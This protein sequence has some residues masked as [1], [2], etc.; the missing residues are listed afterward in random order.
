MVHS[1]AISEGIAMAPQRSTHRVY[2]GRLGVYA[3][4]GRY[5]R[6]IPLPWVPSAVLQRVRGALLSDLAAGY[7]VSLTGD[8]RAELSDPRGPKRAHTLATQALRI[9]G[10]RV[11]T[12]TLS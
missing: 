2:D 7:G 6:T 10:D 5:A 8:A 11:A 12:R 1:S 4:L 3:A 9:A